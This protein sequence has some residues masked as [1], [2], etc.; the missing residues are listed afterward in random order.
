M[1]STETQGENDDDLRTRRDALKTA[2]AAGIAGA[3]F[4]AAPSISSIGMAPAFAQTCSP[5]EAFDC[6]AVD[7][8]AREQAGVAGTFTL[9]GEQMIV[10][11]SNGATVCPLVETA[12]NQAGAGMITVAAGFGFQYNEC[13]YYGGTI[14]YAFAPEADLCS[15]VVM[16]LQAIDMAVAGDGA[17]PPL[18]DI[19]INGSNFT[20]T[21]KLPDDPCFSI[22][23]PD[24]LTASLPD[25]QLSFQDSSV[26]DCTPAAGTSSTA[27]VSVNNGGPFCP[28]DDLPG[29]KQLCLEDFTFCISGTI[30]IRVDFNPVVDPIT[31]AELAAGGFCTYQGTYS[32]DS[33]AGISGTFNAD[34]LFPVGPVA[35]PGDGCVDIKACTP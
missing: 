29:A 18:G 27:V 15:P 30:R 20:A 7:D 5:G 12:I 24:D 11:Q 8:T 34:Q 23:N 6:A 35:N 17:A 21:A 3:A 1:T 10:E 31:G 9:A 33:G 4:V 19:T 28:T 26:D 22:D 2:G 13:A 14:D 25:F 32:G 16:L